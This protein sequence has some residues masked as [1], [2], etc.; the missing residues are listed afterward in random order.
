M[1]PGPRCT[2]ASSTG[3]TPSPPSTPDLHTVDDGIL[4]HLRAELSQP[5]WQIFV[6]HFLG[7]DH[8][9]HTYGPASQAM[10]DK[11]LQMD[12]ALRLGIGFR[13]IGGVRREARHPGLRKD[14]LLQME[15]FL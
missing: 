8:V 2:Q 12:A 15:V 10:E 14:T 3:A 4:S 7:V 9:G 11:L 5:D 6:A 13:V 1:T